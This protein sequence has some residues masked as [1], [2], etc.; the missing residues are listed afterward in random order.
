MNPRTHHWYRPQVLSLALFLLFALPFLLALTGPSPA[1][2][3]QGEKVNRYIGVMK[4]KN[5]HQAKDAGDQFAHWKESK[6]SQAF[7]TLGTAKAKESGKTRGVEEP[8][9]DPKCLKCHETA[10]GLDKKEIMRGFN[11]KE[12]V[13]CET[14]H[15]PGENHMKARMIAAAQ[16]SATA[17]GWVKIPD[18]EII[19]N[20]DQKTCLQCHNEESP[21]FKP[22]C[23]Y[24]F[25]AQIQ[26]LDPQKPRTEA[27]RKAI[28]V[29]GCGDKCTC[30]NGCED[31]KCGVPPK[32]E[33]GKD[34]KGK[35]DKGKDEKGGG[36]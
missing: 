19:K 34:D 32:D 27:E 31:G 3:Q 14:C 33:G 13:Q 29:C 2:P 24:K 28:L 17:G 10:Y 20:P 5:C 16:A 1:Q 25:R 22:F 21:N 4:C 7:E 6:H 35:D 18:D 9:T 23:F 36:K 30:K 8:Q 12:G 26:H 11:P 15:G